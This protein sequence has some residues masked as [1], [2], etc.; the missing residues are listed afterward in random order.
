M[1]DAVL[2]CQFANFAGFE[3][4]NCLLLGC[5]ASIGDYSGP[6]YGHG[7]QYQRYC[8]I[9]LGGSDPKLLF[10][11]APRGTVRHFNQRKFVAE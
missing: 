4:Q 1:T 8:L 7:A 5:Q 2:L 3:I 6:T 10:R 9:G 11:N